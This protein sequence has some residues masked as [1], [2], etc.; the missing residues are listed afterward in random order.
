MWIDVSEEYITIFCVAT[1]R[2]LVY[3]IFNPEDWGDTFPRNVHS[4][5]N[6]TSPCRSC[7]LHSVDMKMLLRWLVGMGVVRSGGMDPLILQILRPNCQF[8]LCNWTIKRTARVMHPRWI[9]WNVLN[10]SKT[11]LK[12]CVVRGTG[13]YRILKIAYNSRGQKPRPGDCDM[14]CWLF[15]VKSQRVREPPPPPANEGKVHLRRI[16]L[17]L[18]SLRSTV[19]T[20]HNRLL[21]NNIHYITVL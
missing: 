7:W 17:R 20:F 13:R 9:L 12:I 5:A 2:T 10:T 8:S 1:C 11:V 19:V 3:L 4:Y 21:S 16:S 18:L 15:T 14:Y 6:C